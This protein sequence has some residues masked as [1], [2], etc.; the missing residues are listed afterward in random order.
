M[1][2]LSAG[3]RVIILI[4]CCGALAIFSSTISK[5]PILA[6][7]AKELGAT[8]AQAGIIAS[9]STIPGILISYIAGD[10]SDRFGYKKIM[11]ASLVVFSSAPLIY[12]LVSSPWQLGAVRFYHGFAT[13]AF[14]PVAMAAIAAFSG[15]NTGQNLSIYSSVTMVGRALAPTV[16]GAAYDLGGY[17]T[18]YVI[19]VVAGTSALLLA[20][21]FF[22]RSKKDM[23]QA[24]SKKNDGEA[25]KLSFFRKLWSLLTYRPLLF[26]SALNATMYFG[27]GAF[28]M[29][30]PLYAKDIISR[31]A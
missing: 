25:E 12:Q 6:I 29:V 18:V 11:I 19:A 10:L 21:W 30:F 23:E 31:P 13:A 8:T 3:T 20:L 24:I 7:F 4:G 16:G 2:K 5:S 15:K 28:E 17:R 22:G 26:A 14:N 1:K 9:M 27:Y